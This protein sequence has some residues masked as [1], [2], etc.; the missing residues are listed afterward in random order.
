MARKRA[1]E[2]HVNHERWLV[3]Y[4]DFITLLFAFFVVMYAISSVNEGKYRVLSDAL[5]AA[6]RS[7]AK[8]LEPIQVGRQ[9]KSSLEAQTDPLNDA[10]RVQ[11]IALPV[12]AKPR[13]ANG[14]EGED[15]GR[16]QRDMDN[17]ADAIEAALSDLINEGS[18]KVRRTDD[19]VEIELNTRILY[20]SGSAIL[21][22][23]AVPVLSKIAKNIRDFPNAIRVEGFTDNVPINTAR[24]P[25]NWE[26][27]AA[28]AA[29]VVHLFQ[30]EGVNPGR[31][32]ATGYGEYRPTADNRT[33][34]GR[35]SNRRVLVTVLSTEAEKAMTLEQ[36]PEV[37]TPG[38][39]LPRSD[40]DLDAP[41]PRP[42]AP[43]SDA[44]LRSL[45]E[46]IQQPVV[47]R[48]NRPVGETP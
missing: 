31:M 35:S 45:A 30:D 5:V 36:P 33:A 11:S 46:S 20:G 6:F 38:I 1:T 47:E 42:S 9:V 32:S 13:G 18:V 2:E 24:F 17:M 37:G 14:V 43:V 21:Q 10:M 28:R 3:S 8:S 4:A 44:Q 40:I 29:S 34:G 19:W 7:P 39:L 48:P 27:S 15:V 22:P 23:E 41:A 12:S 26:L 25:S 16:E